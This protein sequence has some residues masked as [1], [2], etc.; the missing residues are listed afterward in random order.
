MDTPHPP[1]FRR[2]PFLYKKSCSRFICDNVQHTKQLDYWR[3]VKEESFWKRVFL[4]CFQ[5][6]SLWESRYASYVERFLMHE[7]LFRSW[8][9]SI[10]VVE[11]AQNYTI[12]SKHG[13]TS[14]RKKT[15]GRCCTR[16]WWSFIRTLLRYL[17]SLIH[18]ISIVILAVWTWV[19]CDLQKEILPLRSRDTNNYYDL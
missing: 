19:K 1:S 9:P 17:S 5:E 7:F 12:G 18:C 14:W 13:S 3:K 6:V 10:N 15:V 8:T 2:Y 16:T 4:F 11:N